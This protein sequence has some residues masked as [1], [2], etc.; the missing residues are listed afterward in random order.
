MRRISPQFERNREKKRQED[1]CDGSRLCVVKLSTVSR[2]SLPRWLERG[3]LTSF[4]KRSAGQS[5]IPELE[6]PV[7]SHFSAP[8]FSA[9][10]LSPP[11][12]VMSV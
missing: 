2:R 10:G 12:C 7:S 1:L 5:V 4:E 6:R 3:R 8:P 9:W 11:G